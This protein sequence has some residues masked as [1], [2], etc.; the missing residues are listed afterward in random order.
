MACN[1]DILVQQT[2]VDTLQRR[3]RRDTSVHAVNVTSLNN[4]KE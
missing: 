3:L 2:P 4:A 1:E